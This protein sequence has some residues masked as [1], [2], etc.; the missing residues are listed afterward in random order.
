MTK[1]DKKQLYVIVGL[2]GIIATASA[3]AF[4][5]QTVESFHA[6][7]VGF[8]GLPDGTCIEADCAVIDLDGHCIVLMPPTPPEPACIVEHWDKII[9]EILRDPSGKIPHEFLKTQLDIKVLDKPGFVADIQHKITDVLITGPPVDPASHEGVV[10]PTL[11]DDEAGNL[12]LN[13][14]DVEYAI[15]CIPLLPDV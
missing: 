7:P 6:C 8:V 12:K 14:I 11:N 2:A 5:L 15:V 4:P 10:F 13:I 9:F 3:F 1:I